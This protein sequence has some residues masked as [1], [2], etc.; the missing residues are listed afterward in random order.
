MESLP[1]NKDNDYSP[2]SSS[3]NEAEQD[4]VVLKRRVSAF[5]PVSFDLHASLQDRE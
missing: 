4:M 2:S 1:L 3:G 5:L